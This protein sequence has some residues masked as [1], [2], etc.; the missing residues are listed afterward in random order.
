LEFK[1]ISYEYRA[2]NLLKNEQT[3]SDYSSLNPNQGLPTYVDTNGFAISQSAAILEYLEETHPEASLLPGDARQRANIRKITNIIGCD[4]QPIQNLKILKY[5]GDDKKLAWANHW[6]TSGFEA[7]EKQL[8]I[9]AGTYCV[10]DQISLADVFLVPQVY[11]ARRFNVDLSKFPIISRI[12]EAL[13]SVPAF[14]RAHPSKMPDA[15]E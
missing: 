7:L 1:G 11:N 5:V 14:E 9:T 10:G 2:V 4:I 3:T 12:D 8:A 13:T 15:T 6:I